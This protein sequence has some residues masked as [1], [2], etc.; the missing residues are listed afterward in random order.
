MN[1]KFSKWIEA[2]R[3]AFGTGRGIDRFL[4]AAALV[5]SALMITRLFLHKAA[6][7]QKVSLVFAVQEGEIGLPASLAAEFERL[8]PEIRLRPEKKSREELRV[9]VF[10]AP[11]AGGPDIVVLDDW[12]LRDGISGGGL[13]SLAPHS[14]VKDQWAIPLV[15]LA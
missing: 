2:A 5:L 8:N 12:L 4:F 10:E 1:P 13:V 15:F 6:E 11:D 7:P 9:L 3:A 14:G